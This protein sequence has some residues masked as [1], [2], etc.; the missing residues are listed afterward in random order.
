MPQLI[1]IND[2][3]K[4]KWTQRYFEDELPSIPR[5]NQKVFG[6]FGQYSGLSE[7]AAFV[8]KT[9]MGLKDAFRQNYIPGVRVR[10]IQRYGFTPP[11][12]DEIQLGKTFIVELEAALAILGKRLESRWKVQG[13]YAPTILE[14]NL[15]LLLEVTVLHEMVHFFRRRFNESARLNSMSARGRSYEENVARNF[16][17]DTYGHY[18]T[19]QSLMLTKYMPKTSALGK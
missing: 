2:R 17:K 11:T 19:A 6:K 9:G 14:S 18:C 1:D 7:D 10:D 16:E 13:S 8:K 4:Y 3:K 15:F 5:N 12:G